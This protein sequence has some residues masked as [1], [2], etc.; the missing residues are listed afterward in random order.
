MEYEKLPDIVWAW[1]N[2]SPLL[3]RKVDGGFLIEDPDMDYDVMSSADV[4]DMAR[5]NVSEIIK[6]TG[7]RPYVMRNTAE[8]VQ[9][10]EYYFWSEEYP[11]YDES[12][13]LS[14]ILGYACYRIEE[15]KE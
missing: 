10:D 14:A 6:A 8:G 2:A 7:M 4:V 3:L 1:L 13:R 15:I 5:Q 9:D 11:T 12:A